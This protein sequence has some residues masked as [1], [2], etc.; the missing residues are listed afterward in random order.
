MDER[1][2]TSSGRSQQSSHICVL[3]RNPE[4]WSN[5]ESRLNVLLKRLDRCKLEQFETS[6][7]MG[8]SGREVL[9][10]GTDDAWNSWA[11]GQ[12]DTSFGRLALWTDGHPHG[13]TRRPDGL[14]GTELSALQTMQNLLE[15]L[16]NSGIPV[17]KHL[18]KEVILSNRMWPIIN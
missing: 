9:I 8:R 17:K 1:E 18:Y 14:Q 4:A 13:M 5:T 15:E 16:L 10:V 12:Y 3:E 11:F 6:R 2:S 7:H